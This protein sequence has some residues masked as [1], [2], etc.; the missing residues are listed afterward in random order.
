MAAMK[1]V[2]AAVTTISLLCLGFTSS[3]ENCMF[4]KV[5]YGTID[6]WRIL[7]S[8]PKVP[9]PHIMRQVRFEFTDLFKLFYMD[10]Y[11]VTGIVQTETY[12]CI[13]ELP[14]HTYRVKRETGGNTDYLCLQF[15]IRGKNVVQWR[16]SAEQLLPVT[17]MCEESDMTLMDEPLIYYRTPGFWQEER[18]EV[19]SYNACPLEGG[20]IVQ[21]ITPSTG[22]SMCQ[23]DVPPLK[24]ESECAQGL[25]MTFHVQ[26]SQDNCQGA[27]TE[28]INSPYNC[29]ANWE[30]NGFLF[31]ILVRPEDSMRNIMCLRVPA[32]R[33]DKFIGHL[34]LDAVCDS[35]QDLSHTANYR[36]LIFRHYPVIN[37]CEDETPECSKYAGTE[38]DFAEAEVCR[39]SCRVCSPEDVGV[40]DVKFPWP[41]RGDW[42]KHTDRLGKEFVTIQER[43]LIV[44][45]MGR[46]EILSECSTQ[47]QISPSMKAASYEYIVLR[48]Y[49]NGCSP[50]V[51]TLN[52][53][54]HDGASLAYRIGPSQLAPLSISMADDFSWVVNNHMW[55][56]KCD[57]MHYHSDQD[58]LY[59]KYRPFH[60]GWFNLVNTSPH[61]PT[62]ECRLPV[63]N[64]SSL[65]DALGHIEV[66]LRTRTG[67]ICN[68]KLRDDADRTMLRL[69]ITACTYDM[70]VDGA[71]DI[72]T[73]QSYHFKCISRSMTKPTDHAP[74]KRMFLITRAVPGDGISSSHSSPG[75]ALSP[76]GHAHTCWLFIPERSTV[77]W[78]SSGECDVNTEHHV[79]AGFRQPVAYLT[80]HQS[81]SLAVANKPVV[82]ALCILVCTLLISTVL[83]YIIY[84]SY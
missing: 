17:L 34:F 68:G 70:M 18:N 3:K 6:S 51:T 80:F 55:G 83:T 82:W 24:L 84:E 20:Y 25:G 21:W 59:D 74:Y 19:A 7:S 77:Y 58:P 5:M 16:K 2:K 54:Q 40:P 45:S 27:D 46:Y 44:P 33:G 41:F 8:D 36:E 43:S 28:L 32:E 73:G 69:D 66:T 9:T 48:T 78:T 61:S 64:D 1:S 71:E 81:S 13:D 49:D 79:E 65:R 76:T 22:E 50:R 4:P 11:G 29:L 15:I 39:K 35:T 47:R 10:Q 67:A 42:L 60:G 38:C 72:T 57:S 56:F 53:A 37:L 12:E 26:H 62:V 52:L 31:S 63:Y 14:D 30:H 23:K 75:H